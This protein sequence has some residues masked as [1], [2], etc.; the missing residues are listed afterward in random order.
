[1]ITIVEFLGVNVIRGIWIG[2]A[3]GLDKMADHTI[4]RKIFQTIREI[5]P[6][7][8][9]R[10]GKLPKPD[11]RFDFPAR[12]IAHGLAENLKNMRDINSIFVPRQ[13]IES[14]PKSARK[15]E[16]LKNWPQPRSPTLGSGHFPHLGLL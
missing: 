10:E 5:F 3:C 8:E 13:W 4:S 11:L 14:V 1:M 6:Q 12:Q 7:Q 15:R 9:F 16:T 2:F